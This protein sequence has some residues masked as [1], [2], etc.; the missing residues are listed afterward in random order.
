IN[1]ILADQAGPLAELRQSLQAQAAEGLGIANSELGQITQLLQL[2]NGDLA[3][4]E[5]LLSG[6]L[7]DS[8][9]IKD[10]LLDKLKGKLFSD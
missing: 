10:K 2:A 1:G 9:Q 7:G 3:D 5:G 8:K 4:L 6:E